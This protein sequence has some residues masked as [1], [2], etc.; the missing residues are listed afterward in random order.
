VSTAAAPSS[1]AHSIACPNCGAEVLGAYCHD[2]GQHQRELPAVRHIAS[3]VVDELF[4]VDG[5]LWRTVGQLLDNPGALSAAYLAGQRARFLPPLR[6]YLVVSVLY[7]GAFVVLE[8]QYFLGLRLDGMAEYL[9][10]FMFLFLPV[11]ALL[12]HAFFGRVR[13]RY[14]EHLIVALHFHAFA[15][16]LMTGHVAI[17]SYLATSGRTLLAAVLFAL[18]ALL[19]AWVGA[20]FFRTLRAAYGESWPRTAIKGSVLFIAYFA[21]MLGAAVGAGALVGLLR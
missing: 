9:P 8:T 5:R 13:R 2:C 20:G 17:E 14:V 11:S 6:L 12:L 18:D 1:A 21:L 3:E 10:R 15:F 19:L 4:S 16:L 7:F